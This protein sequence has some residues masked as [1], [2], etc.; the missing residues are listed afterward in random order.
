M[1]FDYIPDEDKKCPKCD[2]DSYDV[3][4]IQIYSANRLSSDPKIR[5]DWSYKCDDCDYHSGYCQPK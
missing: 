4:G 5:Y 2:S 3:Y 1:I